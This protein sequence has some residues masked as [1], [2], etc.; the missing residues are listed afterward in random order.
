MARYLTGEK[1]LAPCKSNYSR[2]SYSCLVP[3]RK[4][5]ACI[6]A[7]RRDVV[8]SDWVHRSTTWLLC[9][10]LVLR[11]FTCRLF[12]SATFV[13]VVDSSRVRCLFV[14][15]VL[16]CRIRGDGVASRVGCLSLLQKKSLSHRVSARAI[17]CC[18]EPSHVAREVVVVSVRSG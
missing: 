11:R 3:L 15:C 1:Q 10:A 18:G 12:G 2:Y 14:C 17:L 8:H 4:K 5:W 9:V 13:L 7:A 6:R 16:G